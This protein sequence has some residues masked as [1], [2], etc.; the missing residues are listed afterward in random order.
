[1]PAVGALCDTT[2]EWRVRLCSVGIKGAHRAI[3]LGGLKT[4]LFA[5]GRHLEFE[6]AWSLVHR[7]G[8]EVPGGSVPNFHFSRDVR[9]KKIIK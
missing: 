7:P 5:L 8:E 4:L 6:V 3:G 1:M 2:V 9:V